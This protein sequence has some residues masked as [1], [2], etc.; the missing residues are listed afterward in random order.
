MND[1]NSKFPFECKEKLIKLVGVNKLELSEDLLKIIFPWDVLNHCLDNLLLDDDIVIKENV[2]IKG[3]VYIEGPVF[4]SDGVTI[5]PYSVIQGPVFIGK[6]SLIE[7]HSSITNSIIGDDVMIG[8]YTEVSRAVILDK[9]VISHRNIISNS[10]IGE[11]CWVAGRTSIGSL[12]LDGKNAKAYFGNQRHQTD[13]QKYGA[14]IESGAVIGGGVMIDSGSYIPKT[15][16]DSMNIVKWGG[17]YH[18]H[19]LPNL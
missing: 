12:R 2:N 4:I 5:N 16:I 10:L 11:N 7:A 14:T 18:N 3:N 19:L 17:V 15:V 1:Y 8:K 6:N 13:Y 9:T